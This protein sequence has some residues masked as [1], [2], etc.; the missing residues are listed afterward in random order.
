MSLILK[1]RPAKILEIL[2]LAREHQLPADPCSKFSVFKIFAVQ[3]NN[4]DLKIL[5]FSFI[6]TIQV[7]FCTKISYNEMNL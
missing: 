3:F 6:L 4:L 1:L 7:F 5:K 2:N